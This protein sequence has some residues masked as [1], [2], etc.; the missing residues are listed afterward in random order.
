MNTRKIEDLKKG[1]I[2]HTISGNQIVTY[3]YFCPHPK[4]N[5][6]ILI[7]T[8]QEPLRLHNTALEIILER[9]LDNYEKAKE[10]LIK[11]MELE[12]EFVKELWK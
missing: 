8:N 4:T 7:D 11:V 6:H 1:D 10:E 9:G 2:L 12:L 3:L 5:Y